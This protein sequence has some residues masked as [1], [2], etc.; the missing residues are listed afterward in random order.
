M[1]LAHP[2]VDRWHPPSSQALKGQLGCSPEGFSAPRIGPSCDSK[3]AAPTDCSADDYAKHISKLLHTQ[4][5]SMGLGAV[6]FVHVV[7]AA[8]P[9]F[10]AILSA[11]FAGNNKQ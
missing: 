4:V 10:A 9:V 1:G 5:M 8:E 3:R 6:S 2:P 7:K 11:I